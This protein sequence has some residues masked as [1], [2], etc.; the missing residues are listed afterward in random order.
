M[1]EKEVKDQIF[2]DF[3]MWMDGQTIGIGED[4][5]SEFYERDVRRF[6]SLIHRTILHKTSSSLY[7]IP[8]I[9]GDEEATTVVE[10]LVKKHEPKPGKKKILK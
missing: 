4:G 5:S 3:M 9:H 1:R 7:F 6:R 10:N 8:V 2:E